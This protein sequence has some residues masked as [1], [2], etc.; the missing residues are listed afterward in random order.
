MLQKPPD[1]FNIIFEA[2]GNFLEP[3]ELTPSRRRKKQKIHF[4]CS[5]SLRI[6]FIAFSL[7]VRVSIHAAP[8]NFP[9]LQKWCWTY[10]DASLT[11]GLSNAHRIVVIGCVE[12]KER[13]ASWKYGQTCR[14]AGFWLRRLYLTHVSD[15]KKRRVYCL[16][17]CY[18]AETSR[19][20][21]LKSK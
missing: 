2:V 5:K 13:D 4:F 11:S 20:F 15:I 9:Q 8:K 18:V 16:H 6:W 14:S 19:V 10:L 3:F 7:M 1:T 21:T 17:A 12:T